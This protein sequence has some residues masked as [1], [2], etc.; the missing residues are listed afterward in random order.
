MKIALIVIGILGILIG[1][2]ISGTALGFHLENPRRF[3]FNEVIPITLGGACCSALS[4]LLAA[5]GVIW[6]FLTPKQSTAKTAYD[7]EIGR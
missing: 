3:S 4:L 2:G 5:G 1:L 6:M 7:D